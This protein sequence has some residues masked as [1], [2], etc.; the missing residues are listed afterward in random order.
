MSDVEDFRRFGDEDRVPCPY[1]GRSMF[2]LNRLK[3]YTMQV[4]NS[5]GV[6]SVDR[7]TGDVWVLEGFE[8][9]MTPI[10][11]RWYL[12]ENHVPMSVAK[13][14]EMIKIANYRRLE[15]KGVR[16]P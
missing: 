16:H 8:G 13:Y 3:S 10:R 14:R 9:D 12:I 4:C 11:R 2:V 6:F 7:G 1:C 15:E 5:H